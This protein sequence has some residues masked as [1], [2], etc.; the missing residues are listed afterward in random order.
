MTG[1]VVTPEARDDLQEIWCYIAGHNLEAAD[2]I[3]ADIKAACAWLAAKPGR[4]HFR[5]D[6]T[7]KPLRFWT[8]RK[9][10]VVVYDPETTPLEIVRILHGA[11]DMET[12]LRDP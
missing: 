7:D 9:R 12:I 11:R 5:R 2:G 6:L 10:Y 8:V 4:G 3:E 1:F